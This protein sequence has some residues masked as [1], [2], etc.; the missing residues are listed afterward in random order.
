[1]VEDGSGLFLSLLNYTVKKDPTLSEI[2]NWSP[3][4]VTSWLMPLEVCNSWY[5]IKVDW[6]RDATGCENTA[7]VIHFVSALN[8]TTEH[9]LG[10]WWCQHTGKQNYG[11]T[12][13]SQT[14]HFTI[15]SQVYDGALVIAG[16]HG[17]AQKLLQEILGRGIP[18]VHCM[19]HQLH[20]VVVNTLTEEKTNHR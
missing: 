5:T 4:W 1:M 7:I 3:L 8:E 14:E 2:M 13:K 9:L 17:S 16:K 10:Y 18:Y 20:L 11:R 15:L 6:T 19:N 12:G